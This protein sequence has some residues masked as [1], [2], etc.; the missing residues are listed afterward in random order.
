MNNIQQNSYSVV[1]NIQPAGMPG[2]EGHR[3][4]AYV[5]PRRTCWQGAVSR[6]MAEMACDTLMQGWMQA[7]EEREYETANH[8][9]RVVELTLRLAVALGIKE[10]ELVHY[11][12]GALLHDIGK[13]CIPNSILLK[14]G[15]LTEME[16]E[17][18]RMHPVYAFRLIAP[19]PY[20][21]RALAIPYCHHE[22]WDGSGYPRGL[23]GQRIPLMARI[24][25]V[26]DVFDA[27]TSQRSY[28]Q[29]W[30]IQEVKAYLRAEAGRYFD[31]A[32]VEVFLSFDIFN[33]N[34]YI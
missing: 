23:K 4:L 5:A 17:I 34:T 32:V 11:R 10:K 18:V 28:N 15:P 7:L 3:R 22:K 20:L 12:R 16:R 24:F 31:P 13:M 30:P 14:P 2:E 29:P 9:R 33:E 27:L 19:V 25:S 1:K 26:V 8:C 6:A 21:A